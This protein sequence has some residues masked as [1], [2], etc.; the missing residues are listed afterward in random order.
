MEAMDK[1]DGKLMSCFPDMKQCQVAVVARFRMQ[2]PPSQLWAYE[3]V[4]ALVTL[5]V[6]VFVAPR[7]SR[8]D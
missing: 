2:V 6:G 1:A 7:T 5:A 4:A 3:N 8:H